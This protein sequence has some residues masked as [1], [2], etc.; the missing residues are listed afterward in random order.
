[1]KFAGIDIRQYETTHHEWQIQNS[2]IKIKIEEIIQLDGGGL[3]GF[4]R[5]PRTM[6]GEG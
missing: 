2:L 3:A 6:K 5:R 4:C 1:M